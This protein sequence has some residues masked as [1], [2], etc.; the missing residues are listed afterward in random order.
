M[1]RF[2]G[3]ASQKGNAIVPWPNQIFTSLR[4][5][6]TSCIGQNWEEEEEEEREGGK[7]KHQNYAKLL[8][9]NP[10][11]AKEFVSLMQLNIG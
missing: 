1:H 8:A 9:V 4:H 5:C 7:N 3:S 10:L 2:Y 11:P 6:T